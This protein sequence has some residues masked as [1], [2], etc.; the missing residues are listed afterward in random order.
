MNY[1]VMK[2]IKVREVIVDDLMLFFEWVNDNSVRQNAVNKSYISIEEH[3]EWFLSK[4]ESS[5]T[6]MFV[7]YIGDVPIGQVRFDIKC[8]FAEIDYSICK[9]YRGLGFGKDLLRIGINT[10]EQMHSV[11]ELVGI[12][13]PENIASLKVFQKLGFARCQD[14]YINGN[15]FFKYSFI[16]SL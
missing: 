13:K 12:V 15:L 7:F 8:E 5:E 6:C 3:T 11:K 9:N 4:L 14:I 10:F 2:K 16:R 1:Q